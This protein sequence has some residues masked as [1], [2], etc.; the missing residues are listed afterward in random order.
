MDLKLRHHY[1]HLLEKKSSAKNSKA[2]DIDKSSKAYAGA[3]FGEQRGTSSRRA[4]ANVSVSEVGAKKRPHSD[5]SE[6]DGL[7]CG[8]SGLSADLIGMFEKVLETNK[9][10]KSEEAARLQRQLEAQVGAELREVALRCDAD[11]RSFVEQA[12]ATVRVCHEEIALIRRDMDEQTGRVAKLE[13]A[14]AATVDCIEDELVRCQQRMKEAVAEAEA[15]LEGLIR[16]KSEVGKRKREE[17]ERGFA[18]A[19]KALIEQY[20]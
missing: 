11:F 8:S 7:A 1:H 3:S 13:E 10:S 2:V 17:E 9:R 14:I 18:S 19:M 6:E 15:K 12:E 5:V 16:R 4:A 20:N